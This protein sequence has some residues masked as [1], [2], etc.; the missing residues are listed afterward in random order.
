MN[1]FNHAPSYTIRSIAT[2]KAVEVIM[3]ANEVSIGITKFSG[4]KPLLN[5]IIEIP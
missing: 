5:V 1:Y 4:F 3:V 2:S